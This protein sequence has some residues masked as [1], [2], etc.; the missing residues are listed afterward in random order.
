MGKMLD[1]QVVIARRDPDGALAVIREVAEQTLWEAEIENFAENSGER[2]SSS[3]LQNDKDSRKESGA[4]SFANVVLAGMGGSALAGEILASVLR[5]EL[6]IPFVISR[7][8]DLAKFVDA[9]SLVILVSVS[10]NTEE[11]LTCFAESLKVGATVFAIASG[12]KLID[13]AREN[14]VPFIQL[15]KISQPRYGVI[16]HLRAIAKIL[17]TVNLVENYSA[18]I[19]SFHDDLAEFVAKLLPEIATENN[20]AKQIAEFCDDKTPITYA[21]SRFSPLAYKWKIS[22]NE[23][24]KNCAWMGTLPEFS[25]NEFIGWTAEP[26]RKDF[27]ILDLRSDLDLARNNLRFE[28]SAKLLRENRPA[29]LSIWLEGKTMLEQMVRGC[30]LAD[31]ASIYL[32]ILNNVN[33]TPVVLVEELKKELAKKWW[34]VKSR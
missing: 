31:F 20:L 30:A 4:R 13:L 2:N 25:H 5:D 27:A 12:G 11:T 32:G 14:S 23:N 29:P 16:M 1:D 8:Y 33:P 17:E 28:L 34:Y 19:A 21:S 9:R 3:A 15:Q 10:G 26:E 22:F 24:A 7:D 18:K 6:K